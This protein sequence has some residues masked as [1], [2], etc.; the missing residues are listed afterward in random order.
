MVKSSDLLESAFR[1]VADLRDS[2][3]RNRRASR[4]RL[5]GAP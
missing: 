2:G 5:E 3:V 1:E 4:E